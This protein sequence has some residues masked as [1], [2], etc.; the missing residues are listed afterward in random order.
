MQ[1][2]LLHLILFDFYKYFFILTCFSS[3]MCM[4]V[5]VCVYVYILQLTKTQSKTQ[6][7]GEIEHK[8]LMF[9]IRWL[10]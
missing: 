7:I 1:L 4:Y 2:H 8:K 3:Y 6:H 5:C 10:Y 9:N